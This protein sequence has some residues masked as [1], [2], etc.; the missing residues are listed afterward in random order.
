MRV[1]FD[2]EAGSAAALAGAEA[3]AGASALAGAVGS[4][5]SAVVAPVPSGGAE[6]LERAPGSGVE[7]PGRELAA[8]ATPEGLWVSPTRRTDAR[9]TTNRAPRGRAQG[10]R[11]VVGVT[12]GVGGERRREELRGAEDERGAVVDGVTEESGGVGEAETG[13]PRREVDRV[14]LR[15]RRS[16]ASIS[17]ASR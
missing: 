2:Q 1:I 17:L 9:A 16:A 7:G 4:G 12:P 11:A 10:G 13:P 8:G 15:R 14:T 3:L 5:A 6:G